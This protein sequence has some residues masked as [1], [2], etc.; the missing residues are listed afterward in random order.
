M[1][2]IMPQEKPL[3][4]EAK[5][6]KSIHSFTKVAASSLKL[7]NLPPA[8][9]RVFT[10]LELTDYIFRKSHVQTETEIFERHSAKKK[11]RTK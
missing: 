1:P 4:M 10:Y 3:S 9:R 6:H 8:P 5:H 2:S 11:A 7:Q